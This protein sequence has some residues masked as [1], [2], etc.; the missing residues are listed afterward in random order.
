MSK[1]YLPAN[2]L[3]PEQHY[4]YVDTYEIYFRDPNNAVGT[5]DVCIAFFD[6]APKWVQALLVLR[7]KLVSLIGLKTGAE[8]EDAHK[9]HEEFLA[10]FKGETGE[11]IG[12][13]KV[14]DHNENEMIIG[15]DDKHLD[16]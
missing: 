7:N 11:Q 13:F 16:F 5:R 4:D 2:S 10:N 6:A 8:G 12:L 3:L 9:S 15:E 1:A 14:Y